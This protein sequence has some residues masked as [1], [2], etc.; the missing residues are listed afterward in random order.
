MKKVLS[1]IL[2][3]AVIILLVFSC[4]GCT[5]KSQ[6]VLGDWYF[7]S[8]LSNKN[9]TREPTIFAITDKLTFNSDGTLIV[10]NTEADTHATCTW[11]Y[12]KKEKCWVIYPPSNWVNSNELTATIKSNGT[13]YIRDPKDRSAIEFKREA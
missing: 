2:I 8:G 1:G 6:N 11:E 13:L 7:N 9:D 12:N 4:F 5:D 3:S 10:S